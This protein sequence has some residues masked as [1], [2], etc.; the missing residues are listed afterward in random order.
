M[1]KPKINL[2]LYVV[3]DRYLSGELLPGKVVEQAIK[4]G[5][6]C[7]QLRDK[8]G[9]G[10]ELFKSALELKE[11]TEKRNVT[12]IINDRLDIALAVK[13]DGVHLGQEDL[14]AAVARSIMPEA[15]ILGVSVNTVQQ[16][17]EAQEAG[18]SYLGVGPV[19]S[20]TTKIDARPPIGLDA[21]SKICS[22]VNIPVVGIGGIDAGNASLVIESGAHG[23]AVVSSVVGAKDITRAAEI[24]SCAVSKVLK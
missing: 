1:D 2:S 11:I 5:A 20:T 3:T 22:Q 4:G 18:A 6:A 10:G 23:V 9:A 19:F 21:L 13:A 14:P 7:I 15:M 24:I 16:A 12:F 17:L 8:E